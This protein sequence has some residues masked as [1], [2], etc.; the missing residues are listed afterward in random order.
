MFECW[1]SSQKEP[2]HTRTPHQFSI[3]KNNP[4]E[5]FF[6]LFVRHC[7]SRENG[8]PLILIVEWIPAFAGMTPS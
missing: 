3:K 6:Y 2:Y 7:H 5:D 4:A 1:Y 8:N